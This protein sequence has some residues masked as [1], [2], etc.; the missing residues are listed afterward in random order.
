MTLRR[1]SDLQDIEAEEI[2]TKQVL[3]QTTIFFFFLPHPP[4]SPGSSFPLTRSCHF[5][6]IY[7]FLVKKAQ[8]I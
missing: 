4:F 3:F 7:L 2:L 6:P 5:Q 8:A 1:N